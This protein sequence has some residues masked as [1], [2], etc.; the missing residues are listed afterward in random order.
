MNDQEFPAL[1]QTS[2]AVSIIAQKTFYRALGTNLTF[3]ALCSAVSFFGSNSSTI[4]LAQAALLL[5]TL[6]LTV[7]LATS[8]PQKLW[9]RGRALAESVKTVTWRYVMRAEPF[10]LEDIAAKAHFISSLRKIFQ[11]NEAISSHTYEKNDG[12]QITEKMTKIRALSL[13]DRISVYKQSRIDD[14]LGWYIKKAKFNK[15]QAR[16]WFGIIITTNIVAVACA[17]G[18]VAFPQLVFWPTDI[19]A[20]AAGSLLG[21]IQSKKFQEL[22]ASYSL[23][24][25]EIGLL[26]ELLPNDNLEESFST[27]VG[28]A[29]NAFSREHTQWQARRDKD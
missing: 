14:Q 17:L 21:W 15:N 28:D 12:A 19:F 11:S 25:H 23:T 6:S 7:Y 10:N 1:Y 18:K 22:G 26:K 27:F 8:K 16:L 3:L 5:A 4:A 2:N 24:A 13:Q 29:E 20:A 9:Y